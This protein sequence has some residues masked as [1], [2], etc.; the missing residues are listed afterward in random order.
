M[1]ERSEGP[2]GFQLVGDPHD[3]G[4]EGSSGP[5]AHGSLPPITFGAFVL[6]LSTSAAIHL[7][8]AAP[9]GVG[10]EET[11]E[12]NL[13]LARQ[14]ID[15]LEMLQTKTRGNLAEDEQKLLDGV[16]HDL[17]LRF[18]EARKRQG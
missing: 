14:V 15:I 3:P 7:G 9:E 2:R 13:S 10:A 16:V 18:V 1:G 17:H 5:A 6:S 4:A 11:P 8:T 12:P